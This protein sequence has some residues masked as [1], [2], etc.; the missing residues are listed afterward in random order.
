MS[1]TVLKLFTCNTRYDEKVC[2][3]VFCLQVSSVIKLSH[4]HWKCLEDLIVGR[5]RARLLNLADQALCT[6]YEYDHLNPQ[7]RSCTNTC[8]RKYIYLMRGIYLRESP[9][10]EKY[11]GKLSI[12]SSD[13]STVIITQP[14][15][16]GGGSTCIDLS[17]RFPW[18]SSSILFELWITS[19]LWL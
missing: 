5:L 8:D 13:L 6:M 14:K 15:G 19:V 9:Y 18:H 1:S 4:I 12:T 7:Q 17:P 3:H 11:C 2:M 16:L 10:K